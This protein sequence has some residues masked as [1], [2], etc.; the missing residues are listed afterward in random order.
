MVADIMK[1]FQEK[2]K[3]DGSGGRGAGSRAGVKGDGVE[4]E[5]AQSEDELENKSGGSHSA[6]QGCEDCE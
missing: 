4:R 1:N 5:A 6:R 2:V 3:H